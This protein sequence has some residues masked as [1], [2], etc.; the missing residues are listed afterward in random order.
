VKIL[1]T[2]TFWSK[3]YQSG[4]S[5]CKKERKEKVSPRWGHMLAW[6][7]GGPW[8]DQSAGDI[9][10]ANVASEE[11]SK[12]HKTTRDFSATLFP[13]SQRKCIEV[14]YFLRIYYYDGISEDLSVLRR[15]VSVLALSDRSLNH[16]PS[17]GEKFG[18]HA[19]N[20]SKKYQPV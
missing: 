17:F 5:G 3:R 13:S 2:V 6:F 18:P 14:F 10:S 9:L 1:K 20:I 7:P 12:P 11:C 8:V 15:L 19:I 4:S 16:L